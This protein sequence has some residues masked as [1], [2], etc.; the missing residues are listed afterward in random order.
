MFESFLTR[1]FKILS[2]IFLAC[3][4][5]DINLFYLL[6]LVNVILFTNLN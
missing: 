5:D 1:K 3:N 2:I 6:D 4:V